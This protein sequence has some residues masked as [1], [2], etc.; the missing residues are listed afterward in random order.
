[1][2]QKEKGNGTYRFD[3]T[4]E[5][6]GRLASR[7][8]LLLRGKE[9]PNF[10]PNVVSPVEVTV[11]NTDKLKFSGNKL[12]AKKYYRHSGYPGGIKVRSLE[13]FMAKDSREV[14]RQA[15]YGMLPKNKMRSRL[16]T[17]LKLF[18]GSDPNTRMHPND[19]K[20]F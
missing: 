20:E 16:I 4:G 12:Q 1:M 5:I 6:L 15:V 13:E 19:T 18:K 11:F 9:S 3:A 10:R 2:A 17:K 7:A 8:A 14:F